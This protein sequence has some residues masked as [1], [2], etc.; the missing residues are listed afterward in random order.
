M[1]KQMQAAEVAIVS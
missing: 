1:H